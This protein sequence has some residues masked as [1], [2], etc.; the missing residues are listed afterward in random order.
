MAFEEQLE[1][2]KN[3]FYLVLKSLQDVEVTTSRKLFLIFF[4][5]HD[6]YSY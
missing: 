2:E 5:F 3:R 1:E 4:S 6:Y